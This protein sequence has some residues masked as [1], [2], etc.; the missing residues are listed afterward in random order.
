MFAAID[1]AMSES[2]NILLVMTQAYFDSRWAARESDWAMRLLEEGQGHRVIPL[3]LEPTI[4]QG[5]VKQ[6]Q[7][8]D[9]TRGES[10]SN[11]KRLVE[12]LKRTE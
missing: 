1:H 6:L 3:M 5:P 9:F 2:R 8:M 11:M 4:P 12:V 7:Y 10:R